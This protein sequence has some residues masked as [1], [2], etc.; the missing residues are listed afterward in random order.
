[1][2]I[3]AVAFLIGAIFQAV[4]GPDLD[5]AGAWPFWFLVGL[6]AWALEAVIGDRVGLG[7]RRG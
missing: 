1:M 7:R 2:L 5:A 4:N 6:C 3:A